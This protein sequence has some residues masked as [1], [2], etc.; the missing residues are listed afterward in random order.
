M[1]YIL[2]LTILIIVI[3]SSP[4]YA[5]SMRCGNKLVSTGDKK[6]E[7]LIKCG[8]PLLR[9]TIAIEEKAEYAELALKYPLLYKHGLL[10]NRDG[11][12]IGRETSISR[13]IDQ[14][15]YHMGQGQFLRILI[16]NG[17]ELIA[18]EDGDRM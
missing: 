6:A 13:P 18:I 12:V 11:A 2:K 3:V 10:K 9:E 16:F 8:E 14:W 17:G 1:K 7:V 15:T 5:D 4:G